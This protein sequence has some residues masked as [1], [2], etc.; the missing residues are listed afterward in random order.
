M[1]VLSMAQQPQQ[2]ASTYRCWTPNRT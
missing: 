1:A 2:V